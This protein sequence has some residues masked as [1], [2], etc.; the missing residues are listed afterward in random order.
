MA[1]IFRNQLFEMVRR[2]LAVHAG[3]PGIY[4]T[5]MQQVRACHVDDVDKQLV[6]GEVLAGSTAS[7]S[8]TPEANR[9]TAFT[10]G[11]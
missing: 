2:G 9:L 1:V 8:I 11:R 5:S 7:G 4:P 6:S 10:P 3:A